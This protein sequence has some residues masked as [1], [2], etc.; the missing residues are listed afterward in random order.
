MTF[1]RNAELLWRHTI[2]CTTENGHAHANLAS[3]LGR[4]GATAEAI[5]EFEIAFRIEPD[6]Q[7]FANN[8]GA[9]L[10]Q[11]G[12]ARTRPSVSAGRQSN[13]SR[14]IPSSTRTWPWH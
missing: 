13:R 14:T 2:A 9:A 4:G 7:G 8:Y 12:R 10:R 11:A 6:Q 1:W 5:A 3:T